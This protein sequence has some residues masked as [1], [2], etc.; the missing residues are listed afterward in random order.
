MNLLNFLDN[1]FEDDQSGSINY[2]NLYLNTESNVVPSLVNMNE[3]LNFEDTN[4]QN[5]INVY[6]YNNTDENLNN[7]NIGNNLIFNNSDNRNAFTNNNNL[8]DLIINDHN[9]INDINNNIIENNAVQNNGIG[10]TMANDLNNTEQKPCYVCETT[11]V[12]FYFICGNGCC[13]DCLNQHIFSI[14][15]KYK[16]KVFSDKIKFVCVG[17][18]KCIIEN[19]VFEKIIDQ[20]IDLKNI[21]NEVLFKMYL[22]HADDVISCPK[23]SCPN[24]GFYSEK[25][26]LECKA[27]NKY[28]TACFVN[29][30]GASECYECN[31]CSSKVCNPNKDI[32]NLDFLKDEIF[33]NLK[34]SNVKSSIIKIFTTKYC[35]KCNSPI[36]KADGCKHIECNRC[37]YS[38][39]WK[40]TGDWTTH[41]QTACMGIYSNPF[42]DNDRSDYFFVLF[43]YITLLSILKF[44]SSFYILFQLYYFFMAIFFGAGI[45]V[46]VFIVAGLIDLLSK[47]KVKTVI[48]PTSIFIFIESLLYYFQLHPLSE[49]VYFYTQITANTLVTAIMGILY[50]RKRRN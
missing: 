34:F 17:A 50:Y 45:V 47:Y 23:S 13:L 31:I 33:E 22:A 35:N 29:L 14:L 43:F 36:E 12:E 1:H 5:F 8:N 21:H 19:E 28:N 26:K 42:D 39:C 32:F 2:E 24:V 20:N 11:M 49:K 27:N 3:N 44:I 30:L 10:I 6:S 25:N 9:N 4:S 41:S 16:Q 18:C 48:I 46:N 40:C 37:E 15:E 7:N 38:F